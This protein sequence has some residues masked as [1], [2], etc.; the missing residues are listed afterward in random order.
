MEEFRT[1]SDCGQPFLVVDDTDSLCDKCASKLLTG[2]PFSRTGEK[3]I[4][5]NKTIKKQWQANAKVLNLQINN[6]CVGPNYIQDVHTL[7]EEKR[8]YT[9]NRY[10]GNDPLL[11]KRIVIK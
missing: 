10:D 1:C 5:E 7:M 3:N 8:E 11:K 2:I 4:W 6:R 9:T